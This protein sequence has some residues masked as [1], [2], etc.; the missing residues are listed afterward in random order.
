MNRGFSA[1]DFSVVEKGGVRLISVDCINRLG[2]CRAYYSTGFG[3]VSSMP[4]NCSMNLAMFKNCRNDTFDNVRRNFRIFADACGFPLNR[5]C[6]HRETH[7]PNVRVVSAR[8]IPEDIFDRARYGE[9]DIQVTADRSVALF[10][11]AADC[12]TVMLVDPRH[13]VSGTAHC[14]WRNSLNGTIETLVRTFSACG[15]VPSES[16]AVIGPSICRNHYN[17]DAE[18]AR[19]FSEAGFAAELGEENS[20]GRYP[21]DLREINRKILAARGLDPARIHV[22]PWCTWEASDLRLPSYR[23]DEGLNAMCGGVLFFAGGE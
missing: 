20:Q 2:S 4:G 9:A 18:T 3:G 17:V 12:C 8:D 6:L 22:M 5:I 23:R 15:G 11:Y 13:G 1:H 21:I 16:T 19:R 7:E 14:G 10:V